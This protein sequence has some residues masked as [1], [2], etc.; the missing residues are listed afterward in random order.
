[1]RKTDIG[2][3]AKGEVFQFAGETYVINSLGNKDINNVLC[4]NLKTRKRKWFDL[5]TEVEVER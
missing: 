2:F 3:L 4:I 5:T 1:M